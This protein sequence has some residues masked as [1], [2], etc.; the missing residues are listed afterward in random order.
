MSVDFDDFYEW[1]K[2]RFGKE[3]LKIRNTNHGKEICTHSYFATER[4]ME[5]YKY[6]LW[7]NPSGG[8]S[9]HPEMGSYRCWKTDEMG[10]LI[11]LV[12]KYDNI[13]FHEA[14]ALI[15]GQTSLRSLEEKVNELF[16]NH[17]AYGTGQTIESVKK[18]QSIEQVEN[19]EPKLKLPDFS[20]YIDGMS[21]SNFWKKR[22]KSYLLKRK[23]PTEGL[24][25]CTSDNKDYGNRIII[26]WFD[27]NENLTF[28]NARTMSSNEKA[29]RYMKVKDV[30]QNSALY[31]TVW[32]EEKSKVYIMEGE[33][34]A[35]SLQSCGFVGCA[36][37][38]KHMSDEQ[39][40]MI[41]QYIPVLA[42]DTDKS[43]LKA[44]ID[45]GNS[46]LERGF[47]QVFYIRPPQAYKDWNNFLQ[48]RDESIIKKYIEKYEKPFNHNTSDYLRSM[49]I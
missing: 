8:K 12:A 31:M 11:S 22:A 13:D 48:L 7:M 19:P 36:C 3:N 9:K 29:I 33:F 28:W 43:G 15:C 40:E 5:D 18:D 47:P 34:D 10:S 44:L 49:N 24:Y 32:P 30:D 14:E 16:M 42:F 6:H 20:F 21:E 1:C 37:G 39:I 46:L 41:R 2:D 26:P 27:K 23:I 38:G 4:G 35:I 25:V 17:D 45:I